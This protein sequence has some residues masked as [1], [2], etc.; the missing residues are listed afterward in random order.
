MP[1]Q[2]GKDREATSDR[3][4]AAFR[5]AGEPSSS[6]KFPSIARLVRL[7]QISMEDGSIAFG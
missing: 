2:Q 6:Y 5:A 7:V 4:N 3:P 1:L